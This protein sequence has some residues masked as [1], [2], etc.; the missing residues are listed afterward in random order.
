VLVHGHPV[1]LE[2]GRDRDLLMVILE[3]VEV[4]VLLLEVKCGDWHYGGGVCGTGYAVMLC[5]RCGS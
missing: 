3:A 4:T 1:S 2:E 5:D